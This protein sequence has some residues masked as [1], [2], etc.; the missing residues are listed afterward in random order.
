MALHKEHLVKI[1]SQLNLLFNNRS[2][3]FE[4][5]KKT[6]IFQKRGKTQDMILKNVDTLNNL[7]RHQM[8][9]IPKGA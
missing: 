6:R 4:K 7:R 9:P 3:F 8:L 1:S 2:D 5:K